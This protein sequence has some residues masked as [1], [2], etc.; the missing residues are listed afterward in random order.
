[1]PASLNRKPTPE[2]ALKI[3][4]HYR[5][6]PEFFFK[7]F[8]GINA[9]SKQLEIANSVIHNR[10]TTVRSCHGIGK[11]YIAACIALW[12]ISAYKDSIVVTTAPTWRQVKD[13]LWRNINTRYAQAKIPLGGDV[14]NV[15]GWQVSSSWYA[16]GVSSKDP[17]RIQGYHAESGHLLVICDEAAGIDEPI[18]EGIENV[19][20][21]DKCRKLEIGNPTS[22]SGTFRENHK[23]GSQAH[24]IK[25][26]AFDTPNFTANGI[27]TIEDL[28]RVMQEVNRGKRELITVADYLVGPRWAYERLKK[29]GPNNPMF[30]AR[31]LAEFPDAGERNLIPLSRIEAACSDERLDKIL[32]L[33]LPVPVMIGSDGKLLMSEAE[34]E[35]IEAENDRIRKEALEKYIAEQDTV[36]GV[37]V[38]RFG[39]DST[40][41]TPRWGKIMGRQTT[42]YKEDTM[43]TAGRV[44]PLIRNVATD[45]TAVDVIGVGSG[46]VDRLRELQA[47]REAL[48]VVQCAQ[49]VGVNVA[50]PASELPKE[51][52][53]M[54][55]ANKRAE[56]YWKLAEMFE[57]GD[58]YLMPDEDGKPPED[59]MAELSAIEYEYKGGKIYIEEKKEMKKRLN[60]K[61][62]DHADS[63]V[64]TLTKGNAPKWETTD[65]QTPSYDDYDNPEEQD[66]FEPRRESGAVWEEDTS[67]SGRY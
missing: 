33:R 13:I 22:S 10:V 23:P 29:W 52:G 12:Y 41:I 61:S 19:L 17:N 62:P 38:A 50:L 34:F 47:E 43:Q 44:W 42:H 26:S 49:I 3:Q 37:D 56:L 60:G 7:Y 6:H 66:E 14:P 21:G 51:L 67:W 9:W 8:L 36:R 45:L 2:E 5:E 53:E 30:R 16:I 63:L 27:R 18:M 32:G 54:T 28:E 46:V 59:L 15:T 48:G 40:V 58:I 65:S 64:L 4:A 35:R 31:V 24:R 55:Y 11:S 20:T 1:M 39:G 57:S 25:V